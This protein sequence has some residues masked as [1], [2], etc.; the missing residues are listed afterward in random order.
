[1]VS[2]RRQLMTNCEHVMVSWLDVEN[3]VVRICIPS[4]DSNG[5]QNR[6]KGRTKK[7]EDNRQSWVCEGDGEGE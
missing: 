4:F 5:R 7:K 2:T 3:D 1:M 6:K